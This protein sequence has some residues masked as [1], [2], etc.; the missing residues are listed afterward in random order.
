MLSVRFRNLKLEQF[1]YG[2]PTITHTYE[3][4]FKWS[5]HMKVCHTQFLVV[6][7][8]QC[9]AMKNGPETY[10]GMRVNLNWKLHHYY[11]TDMCYHPYFCLF[12]QSFA[13][14]FYFTTPQLFKKDS[15]QSRES[16]DKKTTALRASDPIE[17]FFHMFRWT[18]MFKVGL[19]I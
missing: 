7:V 14:F 12:G 8:F 15:R 3:L 10:N 4:S 6:Q 16:K 11:V 9:I 2:Y 18:R 17:T 13:I 5:I 1:R 19:A